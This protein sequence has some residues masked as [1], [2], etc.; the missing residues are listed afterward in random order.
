MFDYFISALPHFLLYFAT[1]AVLAVAFLAAYV[2]ITPH[3]EFELI[4]AGS[5]AAAVQLVGTFLGFAIPVAI[6]ISH[7]V[8][9]LDMLIWGVVALVVQL[10]VFFIIAKLFSGIENRI[11][12]NCVAS[13][14]FI[15]GMSLAFGILQAS[16]MVP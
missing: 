11:G 5:S 4:K 8:S 9:L 1:V 13:G 6:V 10:A 2:A 7:S 16:C 12:E 14:I 3:R 15:G